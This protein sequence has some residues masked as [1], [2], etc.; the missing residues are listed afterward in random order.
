MAEKY[1]DLLQIKDTLFKSKS[2]TFKRTA[3]FK[4]LEDGFVNIK[5]NIIPVVEKMVNNVDE[6]N[7][8]FLTAKEF[9]CCKQ[10][11]IVLKYSTVKD[12]SVYSFIKNILLVNLKQLVVMENQIVNS[13]KNNCNP[14]LTYHSV[15]FKDISIMNFID[16]V[17]FIGNYTLDFLDLILETYR[18]DKKFISNIPINKR[19]LENIEQNL[20]SYINAVNTL[21][22][23]YIQEF[24]KDLPKAST[25]LM[26]DYRDVS[27]SI[28]DKVVNSNSKI[29]TVIKTSNFVGNI[30]YHIGMWWVDREHEK[31]NNMKRKRE[32]FQL[33]IMQ[34]ELEKSGQNDEK[35]DNQIKWYREQEEEL[36]YKIAKYETNN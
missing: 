6:K 13:L 15:N 19:L 5:E 1:D 22:A 7:K 11:N 14:V 3:L 2:D 20:T 35:I 12:K 10:I 28:V 29:P 34:L 18:V 9:D 24:M 8:D 36:A 16:T 26:E 31:Y 4:E 32:R 21:N 23:K 27:S 33:T 25:L 30:F 17:V